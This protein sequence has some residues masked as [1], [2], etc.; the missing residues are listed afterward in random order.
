MYNG[1]EEY[2]FYDTLENLMNHLPEYF[3]RCHRSYVCNFNRVKELRLTENNIILDDQSIVPLSRSYRNHVRSMFY[4]SRSNTK[5][6]C[7]K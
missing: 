3:V 7:V 2:E 4:E 6:I 5:G 1:Q